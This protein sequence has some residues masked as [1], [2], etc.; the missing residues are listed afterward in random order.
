MQYVLQAENAL[1]VR[2]MLVEGPLKADSEE[3]FFHLRADYLE[4]TYGI[5][6]SEYE[7]KTVSEFKKMHRIPKHS[8]VYLWFDFDLYCFVHLLFIIELLQADKTLDLYLVRPLRK[9]KFRIWRGFD[10]HTKDDLM[11]AF[12]QKTKLSRNDIQAFRHIW[13][14]LGKNGSGLHHRLVPFLHKHLQDYP[15]LEKATKIEARWGLTEGQIN[16]I[17]S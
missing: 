17:L 16:R 3:S 6:A 7:Q 2:E 10:L 9:R 4:K 13:K 15:L 11:Q 1:V 8:E 14:R 5:S 12:S